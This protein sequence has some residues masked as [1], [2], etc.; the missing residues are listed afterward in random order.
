MKTIYKYDIVA[1]AFGIVEGPI[2]K[3]LHVGVQD[4]S[5]K[6]WAEVDTDLP[7][8]KFQ[9][10]PVGTGW[11]L[12]SGSSTVL[13]THMYI[14]TVL[15]ED[16]NLVFHIYCAEIITDKKPE[17]KPKQ[18]K[19]KSYGED[20]SLFTTKRKSMIDSEILN[21]FTGK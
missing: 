16:G 20:M 6:V 1:P 2:V 21:H 12:G 14:G 19:K 4:N 17:S 13:D 7:N 10:I 8:R 5:I 11:N 18:E 3:L 15:M 9:F